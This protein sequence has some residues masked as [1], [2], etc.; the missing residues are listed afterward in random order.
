MGDYVGHMATG[1]QWEATVYLEIWVELEKR[2]G[3]DV[4]RDVCG[5]AMY[6]AGVRFGQAMAR[7]KGKTDLAAL[8]EVWELLY[9][10][11][12]DTEWDGKRLVFHNKACVIK[13]TLAMYDLA[14]DLFHEIAQVFCEG[15]R[16]FVNG[17]NPKLKF[18]WGARIFRKDDECRWIMEVAR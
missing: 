14:P 15:D 2:Y 16:G 17:F 12:D 5:K 9:P 13:Q 8:K 10:T 11:G 3:R 7:W 1:Y 4:A 18:T 6:D